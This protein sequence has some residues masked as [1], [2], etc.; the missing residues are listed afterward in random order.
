MFLRH[1]YFCRHLECQRTW[2]TCYSRY[3]TRRKRHVWNAG[4]NIHPF[5]LFIFNYITFPHPRPPT[6]PQ[7]KEIC[8]GPHASSVSRRE[9]RR[10]STTNGSSCI[11]SPPGLNSVRTTTSVN[12]FWPSRKQRKAHPCGP[13]PK[14]TEVKGGRGSPHR[15][16][17][18]SGFPP[19]FC[20]EFGR[21]RIHW[22]VCKA[23]TART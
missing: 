16:G 10:S 22:E 15:L 17:S 19:H 8:L 6:R 2:R 7:G 23:I 9:R 13:E 20:G 21:A 3:S 5:N 14:R 11:I 1:I 4:I 12:H 18:P